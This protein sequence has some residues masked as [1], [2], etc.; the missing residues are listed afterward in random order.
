MLR[1]RLIVGTI[2]AIFAIAVLLSGSLLLGVAISVIA[3][4]GLGEIYKALALTQEN[5][6]L[7]VIGYIW[8]ILVLFF[9]NTNQ[10]IQNFMMLTICFITVLMVYMVLSHKKTTYSQVAKCLFSTIY[11]VLFFSYLI[12]IRNRINGE[13]YIWIPIIVAWLSDTMAYTFGLLFGKHKLIPEVSPKKTIEGA[14]GGVFGGVLFMLIYSLVSAYG[15]S[16]D[17]NFVSMI[18][19]GA[20]GAV[21]SQFGDLAASWIKREN[22]IKD[23][24]NLLPGHGGILDRFDSVL[25]IAPFVY[26]FITVFPVFR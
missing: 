26:Y 17:V 5:K 22:G 7:T 15:F 11:V 16:K 18:L 6:A 19:L 14:I 13:Y 12:L 1:E 2:G 25:I 21:L 10:L 4:I 3:L 23:Y 24:G 8:G 20:S 9:A